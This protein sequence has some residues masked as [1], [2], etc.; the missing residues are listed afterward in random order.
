MRSKC[1]ILRQIFVI[2]FPWLRGKKSTKAYWGVLK[3][4]FSLV[5]ASKIVAWVPTHFSVCWTIICTL[6]FRAVGANG[7]NETSEKTKSFI[8]VHGY[9][10]GIL[11]PPSPTQS[12]KGGS[13]PGENPPTALQN[14]VQPTVRQCLSKGRVKPWSIFDS[15]LNTFSARI[16]PKMTKKSLKK[17]KIPNFAATRFDGLPGH[18]WLK[19]ERRTRCTHPFCP[20][21]TGNALNSTF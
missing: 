4:Q 16:Y 12:K 17:S 13:C 11:C 21:T 6:F 5:L 20:K 7:I 19:I 9:Q 1:E 2:N 18:F 8:C 10:P 15:P 14:R 3:V